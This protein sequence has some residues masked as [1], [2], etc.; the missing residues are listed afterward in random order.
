MASTLKM[1]RLDAEINF[2]GI[3]MDEAWHDFTAAVETGDKEERDRARSAFLDAHSTW[4]V[5]CFERE[6]LS[7]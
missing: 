6:L 4:K 7:M 5:A 1:Q 2:L 3:S